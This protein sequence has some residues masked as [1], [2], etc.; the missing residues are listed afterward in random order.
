[1]KVKRETKW[2][3][4]LGTTPCCTHPDPGDMPVTVDVV[5]RFGTNQIPPFL[6]IDLRNCYEY[7]AL[8]V[9]AY[10]WNADKTE[11]IRE[12][13]DIRSLTTMFDTPAVEKLVKLATRWEFNGLRAG[14]RVQEEALRRYRSKNPEWDFSIP[15]AKRVLREL[16][17]DLDVV[18]DNPLD[19]NNWYTYGTYWLVEPL[20]VNVIRQIGRLCESM[21]GIKTKEEM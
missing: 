10:I 18:E 7:T 19:S 11:V 2:T 8:T 17:A 16:S 21:G 15:A 14:T 20:P 4:A 12:V 1:M 3:I 6:D 9:T 13:N 5:L